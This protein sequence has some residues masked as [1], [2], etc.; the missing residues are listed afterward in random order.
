[1]FPDRLLQLEVSV[2]FDCIKGHYVATVPDLPAP[3]V[4]QSLAGLRKRIQA[5]LLPDDV[6]MRLILDR[7]A[8]LERDPAPPRRG[9]RGRPIT[10]GTLTLRMPR[11]A[12]V[13]PSV[14]EATVAGRPVDAGPIDRV[15]QPGCCIEVSARVV[16][17]NSVWAACRSRRRRRF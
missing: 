8:R 13:W 16:Y 3:I 15:R 5:A 1:M 2:T 17:V 11:A 9:H 4:A 12:Q 6:D 7:K 10:P 14:R